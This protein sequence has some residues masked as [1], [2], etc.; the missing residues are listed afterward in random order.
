L[1]NDVL[2]DDAEGKTD[3]S[4]KL[5]ATDDGDKTSPVRDLGFGFG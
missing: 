2:R 1:S 5:R 4:K 3:L